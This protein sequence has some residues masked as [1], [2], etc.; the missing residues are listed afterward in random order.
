MKDFCLLLRPWQWI[1]NLLL[2]FPPFLAG[3]MA[4]PRFWHGSQFLLPI[5]AFCLISSAGYI[6]NDLADC[7]SDRH[8]PRKR[9]RPLTSGRIGRP[10]AVTLAVFLTGAAFSLAIMQRG[11]FCYYLFV[12]AAIVVAYSLWLK[13]LPILDIFCISLL[14]I[15]RLL[16]GGE[17]YAV[18]VSDWLFL[19][20]FLLSIFLSA[21]KRMGEIRLL[22]DQAAAHRK[23]LEKYPDGFLDGT[24]FM[25]ASAVLITYTM[26]L[27]SR[28]APVYS[29]PL[30][31]FGL[32]RYMYRVK[33]GQSGDPTDALLTDLPLLVVGVLWVLLT[34]WGIYG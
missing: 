7:A 6:V 8:H 27:I 12:Y 17:A 3:A 19:S 18:T 22:G 34:G 33:G 11:L 2:L 29:V 1:K 10:T 23:T 20:V 32:L 25:V 28:S 14:F 26:Y 13:H 31:V 21:G 5:L 9:N 30:C 24:M 15:L 16:A 4:T